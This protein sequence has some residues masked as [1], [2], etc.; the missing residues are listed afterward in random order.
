MLRFELELTIGM[1]SF[2]LFGLVGMA[3]GMNLESSLEEA[4]F[5]RYGLFSEKM[6]Y[7]LFFSVSCGSEVLIISNT[8]A[9][10]L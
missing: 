1:F 3:F 10:V 5:F 8:R 4:R 9:Y 7:V 2:G 6:R